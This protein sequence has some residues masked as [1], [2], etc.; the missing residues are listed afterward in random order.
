MAARRRPG[1]EGHCRG[2]GEKGRDDGVERGPLDGERVLRTACRCSETAITIRLG[3]TWAWEEK[4]LDD[5]RLL[6]GVNRFF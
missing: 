2:Q 6:G 4:R 1:D 3:F 5:M